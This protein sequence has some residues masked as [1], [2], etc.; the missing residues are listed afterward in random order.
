MRKLWLTAPL[1]ILAGCGDGNVPNTNTGDQEQAVHMKYVGN[2]FS[3]DRD[4]IN[5]CRVYAFQ[6]NGYY[7]TAILCHGA[8]M[9]A[10]ASHQ[11]RD[12]EDRQTQQQ[13]NQ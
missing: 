12:E 10:S 13:A 1:L 6:L 2:A 4:P 7:Q 5:G 8:A 3:G 9:T 11:R